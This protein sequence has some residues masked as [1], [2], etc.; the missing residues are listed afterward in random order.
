MPSLEQLNSL[1]KVLRQSM[2]GL[3]SLPIVKDHKA[4]SLQKD[5]GE[6][7]DKIIEDTDKELS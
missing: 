5:I 1:K 4:P 3:P 6:E 2:E 7:I